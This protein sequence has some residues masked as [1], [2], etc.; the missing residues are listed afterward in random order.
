M[1]PP[2]AEQ[3]SAA[4]SRC[5][6]AGNPLPT[7]QSPA[8]KNGVSVLINDDQLDT[9]HSTPYEQNAMLNVGF[10]FEAKPFLVRPRHKAS[11][12]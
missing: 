11:R 9:E 1:T 2:A 8:Q 4:M 12:A 7:T 10:R 5:L 6:A 3:N